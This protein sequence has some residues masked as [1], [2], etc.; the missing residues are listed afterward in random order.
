MN[1][2]VVKNFESFLDAAQSIVVVQAD[3]PDADSLAS[4]LILEHLLGD[5]GK[6]VGL[7]CGVDIPLHL[8]YLSGWDRVTKD[9][10][11]NFDASIIVDTSSLTL[12]EQLQKTNQ[13]MWLKSKPCAVIDH[14]Q[15]ELSID[16][17]NLVINEKAVSTG[18]IIYHLCQSAG[19]ELNH[20]AKAFTAVSIL[21]DSL[22]LTS[23]GTLPSS[24]RVIADLLEQG[25]DL[26][27]LESLRRKTMQRSPELI[28]Y[29][30][31][32]L[33]R[34]EYFYDNQIA[35]LSIPWVEIEKYSH[36]YNPAMLAI[37]EMRL[38][39]GNRLAIVFKIYD[40]GKLTAK[41]RCNYGYPIA[42]ELAKAFGGG[43]HPYASGFKLTDKQ[44]ISDIKPQVIQ[45]AHQL[46]GDL[47]TDE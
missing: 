1:K 28:K 42:N 11:N 21:S 46:L 24:I 27:E 40:K 47:K 7:Y 5:M 39:E 44:L 37:D 16:F 18:E 8:T 32:L 26:A 25:V 35:V 29:K 38:A 4:A 36:A 34:I 12:L 19:W 9:I 20:D 10:P 3:N 33:Q 14:H 30:G 31:E 22:G 17:A 43:G 15:V 45:K 13:L 23:E 41:I 6:N 2:Q